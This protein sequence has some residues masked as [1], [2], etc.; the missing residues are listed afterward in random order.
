MSLSHSDKLCRSLSVQTTAYPKCL[1]DAA[2]IGN[3]LALCVDS[4][5]FEAILRNRV[6][7]VLFDNTLGS[8]LEMCV[9]LRLPPVD[10]IAV[11]IKLT[12]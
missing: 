8:L 3:V 4:V 9:R 6:V 12:S 10:V 1:L 2:I 7:A 5:H 11:F